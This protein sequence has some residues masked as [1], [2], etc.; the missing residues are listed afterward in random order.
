MVIVGKTELFCVLL[1]C[2]P[3]NAGDAENGFVTN[4]RADFGRLWIVV[5][6][7]NG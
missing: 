7:K 4:T 6:L 5:A 2:F 1:L 3:S